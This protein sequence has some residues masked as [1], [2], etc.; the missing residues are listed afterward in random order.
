M[1]TCESI[2]SQDRISRSTL[3]NL[4]VDPA[5]EPWLIMNSDTT[6]AD[7]VGVAFTDVGAC[8]QREIR[9]DDG[10]P[11]KEPVSEFTAAWCQLSEGMAT[12]MVR[13]LICFD[14]PEIYVRPDD[15]G[16]VTHLFEHPSSLELLRIAA[17]EI[18]RR[19]G[20]DV[21]VGLE[22][23]YDPED[24][25]PPPIL[26]AHIQ[27]ELPIEESMRRLD[28]YEEEWWLDAWLDNGSPSL[29]VTV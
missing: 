13:S 16:V 1:N 8:R 7:V 27:A 29:C 18:K 2:P 11:P 10:N 26:F 5:E 25:N 28:Q 22:L 19:F 15:E 21:S 12:A 14:L 23:F 24:K 17:P 20:D 6:C 3:W 9:A 4:Q